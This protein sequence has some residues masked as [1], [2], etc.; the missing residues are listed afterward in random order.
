MVE[1]GYRFADAPIEY[2]ANLPRDDRMIKVFRIDSDRAPVL[3]EVNY[4]FAE[5]GNDFWVVIANFGIF[6]RT[7]A[8]S[9]TPSVQKKFNS[10]EVKSARQRIEEYFSSQEQK[11]FSPFNSGRGRILGIEFVDGWIVEKN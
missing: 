2:D 8:G 5:N 9:R 1:A 6:E 10:V 11:N 7:L 3:F 4:K